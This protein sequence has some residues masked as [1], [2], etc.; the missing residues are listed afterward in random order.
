MRFLLQCLCL[1]VFWASAAAWAEPAS[2]FMAQNP[3]AAPRFETVGAGVIPRDVVPTL[4]QDTA[5]FLWV[6]TGD[7]LVRYDGYRFRP[8]ERDG[9]EP[10]RRNLGWIRVLLP[11]KDGRLW[12][13]TETD[14]LAVYDPVL[15]KVTD[16][17]LS[18]AA[19]VAMP[20][21]R[22]LAEDQ[23][24]SIWVGSLGGG[25]ARF[26]PVRGTFKAYRH[27]SQ[28]GSLPDDRVQ[29][30]LV[31]REGTLWI[32][33]WA[34]LSR[35]KRGSNVFEPVLTAGVGFASFRLAGQLVQA[36]YQS[37]DGRIWVGTQQGRVAVIDPLTL[38][39]GGANWVNATGLDVHQ[40]RVQ[41]CGGPRRGRLGG[42]L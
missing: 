16:F 25:L 33:T 31:D 22:A 13:G 24:G 17:G 11:A 28:S 12:M 40:C 2:A 29:A 41:L 23:D 36:L 39:Y 38:N 35:L 27:S 14:G 21:V 3:L 4:A 8:L 20:T 15:E 26:D 9:V 37:A 34:G 32:G 10:A 1:T 5:G 6:A 18:G 19:G 42:A 30:L 7:G